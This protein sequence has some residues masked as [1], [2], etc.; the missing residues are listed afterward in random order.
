MIKNKKTFFIILQTC[1]VLFVYLGFFCTTTFTDTVNVQYTFTKVYE[2]NKVIT[3]QNVQKQLDTP[4][5]TKKLD[6]NSKT[7]RP[8]YSLYDTEINEVLYHGK[9]ID[10]QLSDKDKQALYLA[11]FNN[12]KMEVVIEKHIFGP[13]RY[14]IVSIPD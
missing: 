7:V 8:G 5:K 2:T 4:I 14:K 11:R 3:T 6:E 1:L 13:A 12:G 10:Y 9:P